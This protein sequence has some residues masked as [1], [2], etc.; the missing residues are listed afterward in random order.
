MYLA[1]SKFRCRSNKLP[2]SKHTTQNA[3]F[4]LKMKLGM[5]FVIY[6]FVNTFIQRELSLLK[7]YYRTFPSFYKFDQLLSTACI[8]QQRKLAL[9]VTIILKTLLLNLYCSYYC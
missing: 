9:V 8:K 4:A 7:K 5:N 6:L 1:T 3:I 2:V